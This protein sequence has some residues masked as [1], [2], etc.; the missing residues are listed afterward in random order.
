[1]SMLASY[2]FVKGLSIILGMIGLVGVCVY[3]VLRR[4][5][6]PTAIQV[7]GVVSVLLIAGLFF[8]VRDTELNYGTAFIIPASCAV[9]GISLAI[10][11]GPHL[12]AAF[13]S[14]ITNLLSGGSEQVDLKPYYSIAI[15]KRKAAKYAEAIEAVREQL[16]KFPGDYEGEMLLAAIYAE[17][18]G[19]L[20]QSQTVIRRLCNRPETAPNHISGAFTALADW[21]MHAAHDTEIA[22]QSLEEICSRLP[23]S[24]YEH[25]AQQRLAHLSS[26]S[27]LLESQDRPVI[28]LKPGIRHIGLESSPVNLVHETP[29]PAAEAQRLVTHL[30]AHPDDNESREELAMVYAQGFQRPEM[31]IAEL[32]HLIARPHQSVKQVT[33]WLNLIADVH[34]KQR[35]DVEAAVGALQRVIDLFPNAAVAENARSRI[36]LLRLEKRSRQATTTL[37]MGEYEQRIGLK[38][39]PN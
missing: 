30:Q 5:T 4:S 29:T 10:L 17:N 31:A 27:R 22:R 9:V 21:A 35:D 28:P 25:A 3:F 20:E 36:N 6:D 24:E 39:G 37:T 33:H 15:S 7:K 12:S 1:M 13:A 11:W 34:V 26:A 19:D 14:P 23:G 8:F 32:E 38:K 18:L 2:A 16:A